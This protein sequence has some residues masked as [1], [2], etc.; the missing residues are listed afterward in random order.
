MLSPLSP[1]RW[2]LPLTAAAHLLVL[3]PACEKHPSGA[4]TSTTGGPGG[5]GTANGPS[6]GG[7]GSGGPRTYTLYFTAQKDDPA[8]GVAIEL[9]PPAGWTETVDPMG[10][11]SY[12]GNGLGHGPDVVLVPAAGEP[13][14][15]VDKLIA[16]HY[17]ATALASAERRE[18]G[19]GSVWIASRRADGYVD[20]RR[21]LAAPT[22]SGVVVCVVTLTPKEA[23]RLEELRAVC[24]T[25]RLR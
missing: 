16:R 8:S 10:G 13:K 20:A 12:G 21:F 6:S 7:P 25:L 4:G 14:E 9:A 15:R 1:S 2:A 3:G 24:D 11:P 17:D 18:A 22:E 23:P 5:S 19:D